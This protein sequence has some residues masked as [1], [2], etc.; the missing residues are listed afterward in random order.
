MTFAG[1]RV[2][3]KLHRFE[4]G[5]A[6]LVATAV[7]VWG[8]FIE[9]RLRGLAVDPSCISNWLNTNAGDRTACAEPMRAW[10]SIVA[11]E[12]SRLFEAMRVLPLAVGLLGGVPIV[13]R[14]IEAGTSATAWS[15]NPSR[16]RWL[17]NQIGPIALVLAV[18]LSATAV[19]A[20]LVG[21]HRL[22]WGE[23]G[24]ALDVGLSGPPALARGLGAFGLGL[25]AGVLLGRSLPGLILGAA[26]CFALTVGVGSV[27]DRWLAGQ[28]SAAI[29]SEASGITTGFGWRAPDGTEL[30]LD[31]GFALVPESV[32][33]T[34]GI[35]R[36][37]SAAWLEEHGYKEMQVGVP[38]SVVGGWAIYDAGFFTAVGLAGIV[39]TA[40]FVNRRRP[41]S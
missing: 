13:A 2:T 39:G 12:G 29:T 35:Q 41:T 9:L 36:G 8:A 21:G 20:A 4:I 10:G 22:E 25:L 34:D 5:A 40:F 23:S 7:A 24:A 16:V 18:C 31:A 28:P 3:L 6:V 38:Y 32:S 26:L 17:A 1:P 19:A 30:S 27:R 11:S 33:A 15:L 14:E 37:D